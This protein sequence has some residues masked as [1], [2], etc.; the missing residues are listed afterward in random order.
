[1]EQGFYVL[2]LIAAINTVISL[3]Y[4][5]KVVKAMF[6]NQSDHPIPTLRTEGYNRVSL[7]LCTVGILVTGIVSLFVE[8]ISAF[9]FGIQ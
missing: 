6:I 7:V 8:S 9:G 1:M 3:Y 5:L 2:V 4:Y